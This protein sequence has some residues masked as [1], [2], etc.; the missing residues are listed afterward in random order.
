M[1]RYTVSFQLAPNTSYE[2]SLAVGYSSPLFKFMQFKYLKLT[3]LLAD[4]ALPG[5]RRKTKAK[6]ECVIKVSLTNV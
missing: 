5:E 6:L 3:I 4:V 2:L 1:L